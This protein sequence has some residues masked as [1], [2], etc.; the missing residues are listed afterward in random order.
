M[1]FTRTSPVDNCVRTLDLPVTPEQLERLKT[2]LIQDVLPHLTAG[3]R[4]FLKT[5]ITEEQWDALFGE[6]T[7]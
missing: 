3:Q 2:G 7:E 5:G 6:D 4:E 1:L